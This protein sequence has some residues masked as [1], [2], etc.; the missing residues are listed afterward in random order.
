M[1]CA[2]E[3]EEMEWITGIVG[4]FLE[5]ELTT[6]KSSGGTVRG[7]KDVLVLVSTLVK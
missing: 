2:L 3:G 4:H 7:L 5:R 1:K 6:M